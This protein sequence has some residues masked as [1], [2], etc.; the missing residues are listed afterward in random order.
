M[1]RKL[2]PLIIDLIVNINLYYLKTTVH[3][4]FTTNVQI[5]VL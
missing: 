4:L 2:K 1:V 3:N 5:G